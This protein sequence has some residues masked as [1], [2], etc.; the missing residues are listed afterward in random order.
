MDGF[1]AAEKLRQQ[2]RENFELLAHVPIRHEYIENSDNHR[3]HMNGIGPVLDV[4]PWNNEVYLIR[5]AVLNADVIILMSVS[6]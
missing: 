2:S 6:S 1:H 4:Y 5:S 3:N